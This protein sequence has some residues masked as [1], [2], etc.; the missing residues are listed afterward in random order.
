M[1]KIVVIRGG[2]DLASGIA[3]R[4]FHAHF[5]VIIFEIDTPLAVRRS[6]SFAEA[7][8]DGEAIVEGIKA[9]RIDQIEAI[10]GLLSQ[11]IIPVIVDPEAK[12]LA[13]LD[14]DVLIDARMLKMPVNYP[15]SD[16][17]LII[18]IGPGFTAGIDCHAF[19]ET[20]RGPF[21]GRVY[22]QGS[23]EP[24]T[25]SPEPVANQQNSRVLRAP[26]AGIMHTKAAIG[27]IVEEG[28][29]V[30]IVDRQPVHSNFKGIVRGLLHDGIPVSAGLKIGDVDP[31]IDPRLCELVSDKALAIGGGVL[32]AILQ[33][34][35]G[36]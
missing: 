11:G 31:R 19:I 10:P 14:P 5:S 9:I 7:V 20:K 27:D 24:D 12:Y 25:G 21:L 18:G 36:F 29:V 13:A 2:G 8:Y 28:Q 22:W 15:L 23:A 3:L 16:K 4:L 33:R 1:K 34:L 32:E 26:K 17:P 30:A 6:V 35:N